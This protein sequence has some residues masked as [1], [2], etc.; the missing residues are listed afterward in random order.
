ML[1]RMLTHFNITNL[2]QLKHSVDILVS[3]AA[4]N[5][6]DPNTILVTETIQLQ[7][8]QQ[9]H[10]NTSETV[11]DIALDRVSVTPNPY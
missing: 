8:L 4:F 6:I 2:S 1:H 3:T 11:Y 9:V 7:L 5:K 10:D